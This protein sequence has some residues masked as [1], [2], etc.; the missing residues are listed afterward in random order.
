MRKHLLSREREQPARNDDAIDIVACATVAYS[1][2]AHD[3]PVEHIF[4]GRRGNGG[5]RWVAA[6]PDTT[7]QILIEFDQAQS[8]SRLIYEV[9]EKQV[10]RTQEVRIE[11]L[12][13]GFSVYRTVLMQQYTFSP[14][15]ATFQRE[16][17][18]VSLADVTRMRLTIVPNYNGHGSATL[19]HF[20]LFA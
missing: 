13:E 14:S 8:I 15:G 2:E 1:S 12:F 9:E 11:A 10:E 7:D 16:D 5:T 20:Q 18:R 6:R 3:H 19:T 17:L 4:D